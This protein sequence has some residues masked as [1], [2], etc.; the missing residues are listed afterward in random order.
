MERKYMAHYLDASFGGEASNFTLLGEDLEEFNIELNPDTEVK[1][2]ILGQTSFKHNGY[3]P[4]SEVSP[5]YAKQG[6]PLFEHLQEIVDTRATGD[7][8]KTDSLEVHLWEG[9]K[10]SGFTAWKQP[11][12]VV[13]TSYGGDTSGYQIPFTINYVGERVKGKF[14]PE[15]K[16]F[17]ADTE[18]VAQTGEKTEE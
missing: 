9:D 6:D 3:E 16:T 15:T 18:A 13:P 7:A 2:N 5:Y 1:K 17:T 11:C 8:C 14:V 10:D 12:Y 4:S